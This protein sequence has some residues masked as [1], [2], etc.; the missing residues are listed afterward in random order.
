[1]LDSESTCGG[2]SVPAELA[3]YVRTLIRVQLVCR[4]I[5]GILNP[6]HNQAEISSHPREAGAAPPAPQ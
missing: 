2:C 5:I 1:M 3:T 4:P 6:G